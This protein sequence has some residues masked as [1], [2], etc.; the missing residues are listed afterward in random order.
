MKDD[1]KSIIKEALTDY[2]EIM[3]AADSNAKKIL[4]EEFP[5]KFNNLLKEELNKNKTAKES[6][7]KL[8]DIKESNEI[9]ETELNK[10]SV[11]DMEN[12][13]N[14]TKKVVKE[15]A[16]EGK[17]FGEKAKKVAIVD[18]NAGQGKPFDTKAKKVANVDENAGSGKP[19][20][21]KAKRPLQTEEYDI[22][23]LDASNVGSALENAGDDDEVLTMEAIEEEISNMKGLEENMGEH[24][25]QYVEED[26][27]GINSNSPSYMEK[28]NKGDAFS[29][30][31]NKLN[32]V[33]KGF[34]VNE[35]HQGKFDLNKMHQG[36][37]D[38]KL[39][40]EKGID[41]M[42]QGKYDLN[43]MHQGAYDEKLI[44]E[45]PITDSDI[46]EVLGKGN[47][48]EVD[49]AHGMAYSSR[50]QVAGRNLPGNKDYLSTGE[51]DQSPEYSLRESKKVN[52]LIKE[53][54][55]LTKK[56]NETKNYKKS[57]STLLESYKSALE[58]YRVQLKEMAVFNTNLAHVNN[59]LVNEELAL[60][61]ADKINIINEFKQVNTIIDSQKKYKNFLTEMKEN[62]KTISE[63]IEEKISTS[64]QS[65]SK[66]KLDEVVEKTAY[67]DNEHVKKMRKLI[68]Y[69]ENRGKKIN[70]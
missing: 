67:S 42:H 54:K 63:S 51:Q 56:L 32:E 15:T 49:E 53:N 48:H 10:E 58:K 26:I 37:Y 52:G 21:E 33:I 39:I 5:E 14:E 44:D 3:K 12:Q 13:K 68:E 70:L 69:V 41:E 59:L 45:E 66:Q 2:N 57:V 38:E 50:R 28:G 64:V 29:E 17:P 1:K 6:Y 34:G 61:Q 40:D 22:T 43:K 30:L 62:R 20:G 65:S 36:A 16:G 18:E 23:E 60:T 24:N 46:E 35:M 7:K 4:A 47:E 8:D 19:F 27:K 55:N 31:L 9:D 25:E 11:I